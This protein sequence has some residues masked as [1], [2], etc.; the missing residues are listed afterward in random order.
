MPL[1]S[2]DLESSLQRFDAG[3]GSA[4]VA[5]AHLNDSQRHDV[6]AVC[7][8][9]GFEFIDAFE[10]GV[11]T[12]SKQTG[13]IDAAIIGVGD[14]AQSSNGSLETIS[15]LRNLGISVIA[16]GDRIAERTVGA[17]CK[18]LL[19]GAKLLLDSSGLDFRGLLA[20][21]LRAI[22]ARLG[23]EQKMTSDV[24]MLARS[25]GIVGES[26]ALF[27]SF[28]TAVQISKLSDLPVLITG[29]SGTGK[30]L[31]ASALHAMDPKRCNSPFVPVN[32]A[33]I[34]PALAENE[35]FGHVRG[36][37]TGANDSRAGYFQAAHGGVLFLDEVGELTLEI[38]AKLLRVLQEKRAYRVGSNQETSVDIRVI[39][40]TNQDLGRMIE[41]KRFRAD[42]FHRLNMLPLHLPSIRERQ[43]DI[44]LLIG[45]F[46]DTLGGIKGIRI[47]SDLVEALSHL[48]LSGNV[49]ELKNLIA[50]AL[51]VRADD[52]SLGLKDLS[53]SVW[54]KLALTEYVPA[55]A[56][57]AP[58]EQADETIPAPIDRNIYAQTWNLEQRLCQYERE[59]IMSALKHTKFNQS[60]A[61]HLLGI[62]PRCVYN[63]LRR[64]HLS[65]GIEA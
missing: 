22:H 30:E 28:R 62:T 55:P 3:S 35:F 36:A 52:G 58:Q 51:A 56:G 31:F 37:F 43:A 15:R 27:D 17:R 33:A 34:N 9:Q 19:A 38:Q 32:C 12:I 8:G 65:R 10:S 50:A 6:E 11:F 41:E 61:A 7:G 42:L 2:P 14:L 39:A 18:A 45:H 5:L 24:L 44:P 49:R 4:V 40:A 20:S 13:T 1:V 29:E 57:S 46:V 26:K 48:E 16:C 59:I 53:P 21:T 47:E 63:K 54:R 60:Q 23:E 25:R 64:H